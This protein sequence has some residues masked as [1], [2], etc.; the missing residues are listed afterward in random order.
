MAH[1]PNILKLAT[2]ISLESLT[3]TGITY[4]DP[5]Y[6]ILE[7]IVDDD[8]CE[9]MMHLRLEANR[10]TEEIA[11]RAKKDVDFTRTQLNKL[12]EAGVIRIRR[13]DGKDCWYYP[14]WV[15]GIMEGGNSATNTPCLASALRSTPAAACPCWLPLWTWV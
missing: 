13:V 10:T 6:K 11:K 15:P 12:R 5:E 14:I 7:P 3:Y 1:R 2:K 9:I 8:M 4:N